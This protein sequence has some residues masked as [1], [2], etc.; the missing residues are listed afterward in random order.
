MSFQTCM[1]F[2]LLWNVKDI[3]NYVSNQTVLIPID[4]QIDKNVENS[5]TA[6]GLLVWL[7]KMQLC[8]FTT[9]ILMTSSIFALVKWIG[10]GKSRE[11]M[12]QLF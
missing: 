9:A 1:T 8:C 4:I 7:F 12:I 6:W 5:H 10:V 3:L 2:L 11:S